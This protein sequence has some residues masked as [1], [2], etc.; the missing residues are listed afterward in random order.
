MIATW[1][2][3]EASSLRTRASRGANAVERKKK[4]MASR[5]LGLE[6]S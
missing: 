5:V 4:S 1:S 2:T 3:S 6:R